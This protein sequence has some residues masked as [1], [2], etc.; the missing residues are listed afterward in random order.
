MFDKTGRARFREELDDGDATW[1]LSI[2]WAI[3]FGSLAIGGDTAFRRFGQ[4]AFREVL[5]G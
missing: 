1:Q 2:G 4:H 3:I 5:L